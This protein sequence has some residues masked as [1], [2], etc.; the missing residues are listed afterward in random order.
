VYKLAEKEYGIQRP[1]FATLFCIAHLDDL[2][3]TDI[4]GMTGIAKN[5]ISRAVTRLEKKGCLKRSADPDDSRS[6]L[7]QIT[8]SGR[9]IYETILPLL[10]ARETAMLAPLART[11][12]KQLLALVDKLIARDVGWSKT[13]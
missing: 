8:S 10:Q 11:E 2:S 5:T 6:A 13:Y 1:M 12:Q 4:C 3:A 7:L 9:R